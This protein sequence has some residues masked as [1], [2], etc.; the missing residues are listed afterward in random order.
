MLTVLLLPERRQARANCNVIGGRE[1]AVTPTSL[2]REALRVPPYP[3]MPQSAVEVANAA[4]SKL[5]SNKFITTLTDGTVE[6]I[7]C[8]DRLDVCKRVLL[9]MHPWNFAIKRKIV[10][11]TW[12]AISNMVDN[13]STLCRV[14]TTAVHGRATG[15]HVTVE[16]VTGCTGNGTWLVTQINTTQLDFVGSRFSGTYVASALDQ[17]TQAPN[18]DYE[19]LLPLPTD[20]LRVYRVDDMMYDVDYRIEGRAIVSHSASADLRYIYDVTDYTTMDALFYECLAAYLAWDICYRIDQSSQLKQQLWDDIFNPR[21]GLLPKSRF[22]DAT[23]DPN[24]KLEANDWILSRQRESVS[25][26]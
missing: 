8:N 22:T 7:A 15:D 21:T 3:F 19:Y 12:I 18:F 24:E 1:G 10:E 5:G 20:C 17:L 4:L 6:S 23:E 25:W 2:R 13:G 11:P 14:T 16:G 26:V 9:R